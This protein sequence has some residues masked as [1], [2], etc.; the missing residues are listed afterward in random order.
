MS[1]FGPPKLPL[2]PGYPLA[3]IDANGHVLADGDLVEIPEMPHSLI[4]DLPAEEDWSG[5]EEE[6]GTEGGAVRRT[7]E[8]ERAGREAEGRKG[9]A[10]AEGR[11]RDFLSKAGI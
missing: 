8:E 1:F 3:P 2:P 7:G 11:R 10:G 9:K 6:S 5:S 4:H